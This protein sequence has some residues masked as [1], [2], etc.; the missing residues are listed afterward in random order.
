MA[1]CLSADFSRISVPVSSNTDEATEI[2]GKVLFMTH[3]G[4]PAEAI[5]GKGGLWHCPELPILD[6]VLNILHAPK[7]TEGQGPAFGHAELQKV[8]DWFRGMV[9]LRDL[10]PSGPSSPP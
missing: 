2:I 8:A 3:R 4:E 6:R 1:C 9:K 10:V 5:L 7:P